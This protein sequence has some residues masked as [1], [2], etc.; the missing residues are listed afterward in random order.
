MTKLIFIP[1]IARPVTVSF[2]DRIKAEKA[3]R[4]QTLRCKKGGKNSC[5]NR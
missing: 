5:V 3:K 2:N 4:Y 1:G